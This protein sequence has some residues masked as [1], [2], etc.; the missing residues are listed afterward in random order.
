M[1]TA[2]FLKRMRYEECKPGVRVVHEAY[3]PGSI[4][5]Q[6]AGLIQVRPDEADW[7]VLAIASQLRAATATDPQ[8]EIPHRLRP[9]I[10]SGLRP[11]ITDWLSPDR[12]ERRSEGREVVKHKREEA[13][14]CVT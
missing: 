9:A 2:T 8:P 6:T 1:N 14:C 5:R 3:G 13:E 11:P 10:S 7:N 4:V 12:L